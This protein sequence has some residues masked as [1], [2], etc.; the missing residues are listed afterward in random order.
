MVNEQGERLMI[1]TTDFGNVVLH[2][3]SRADSFVIAV[4]PPEVQ[5]LLG[6][7][8]LNDDQIA[9]VL[10]LWGKNNIGQILA[11]MVSYKQEK[12]A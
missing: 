8:R 1:V 7:G 6:K 9:M 11:V 12:V 4:A 5:P 2:E 3:R 10:G